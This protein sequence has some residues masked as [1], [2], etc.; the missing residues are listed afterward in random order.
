M[1]NGS[2]YV[3]PSIDVR[4]LTKSK[5]EMRNH[6]YYCYLRTDEIHL[7]CAESNS[8]T[9]DGLEILFWSNALIANEIEI[10]NHKIEISSSSN[11]TFVLNNDIQKACPKFY[12]SLQSFQFIIIKLREI[13]YHLS[14]SHFFLIYDLLES[15]NEMR[16]KEPSLRL[17]TVSKIYWRR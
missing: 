7:Y 10:A 4:T 16:R 13:A 14:T 3:V 9:T 6:F 2:R 5:F 11:L 15:K 8:L 17:D 1:V 12:P